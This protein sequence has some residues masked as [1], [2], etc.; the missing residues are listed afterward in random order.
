MIEL[1]DL[2]FSLAMGD[3]SP[4]H[5]VSLG[6][7]S[8]YIR[9]CMFCRHRKVKCDRQHPCSN[10]AKTGSDCLYPPGPGRA[11]KRPRRTMDTQ[12]V[13]RLS[14]L[15]SIIRRLQSHRHTTVSDSD[16]AV[17]SADQPSP[18]TGA[19]GHQEPVD[20]SSPGG[21]IDQHMG[22]LMIDDTKSYYVSNVLWASLGDEI[23]E[24]RDMLHDSPTDEEDE[25]STD[26]A[27]SE[28][29][30]PLMSNAAILGFRALA[31]SLH[32]FHPPLPVSVALS[33]VFNE[34]VIPLVR[35]FHMPT[36]VRIYWDAVASLDSLDKNTEALLFA[37]YYSAVISMQPEQCIKMLGVTR[38]AA[39]EKYRFAVEQAMARADLLNT[40]SIIL[41]QAAV[42]Y[43]SALRNED[44]SRKTW[45]LTSLIYHIAQA[46]GLHRDGAAFGLKPLE[47]ELR[48]RLWYHIC[49]LD[50][51]SEYHGYEP[52]A[53]ESA[54]DTRPPL[55][56]NDS[57]LTAEMTEPPPERE[58]VTEMTFCLMRCQAMRVGWKLNY[59]PPSM[60]GL[61]QQ[62]NGPSLAEKESMIEDLEKRLEQNYL[63]HC[64]SS[65]PF[66]LLVS[67]VGR[68]I[69]AR[70]WLVVH[71]PLW[72]KGDYAANLN[73][74]MRDRLFST[75]TKV[76]ELSSQLLTN[77][78]IT[79]WTWH[80]RTHIQWHAVAFA[81][82]EI[83]SRPPSPECDRAWNY[84][85][86]LYDGWDIQL[87][88]RKSTMWRPIK[89][90]MAKARYVREVQ[91]TGSR[92]HAA[93]HIASKITP[94]SSDQGTP[95]SSPVL[96]ASSRNI[97]ATSM[98]SD[99]TM[100]TLQDMFGME[101]F[102]HLTQ[103]FPDSLPDDIF[104][105]V[106]E[107]S[108]SDGFSQNTLVDD[109]VDGSQNIGEMYFDSI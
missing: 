83:C 49:L 88:D 10:C 66:L 59:V 91:K 62:A 21:S 69:T 45:S 17:H 30:S 80:S 67:T 75:S 95:D 87:D 24:L 73:T 31:H 33:R 38:E 11:P 68:L 15:E 7:T 96:A 23:E 98:E 26:T 50:I 78:N 22:R 77:K 84:V 92:G 103:S 93:Q 63:Q 55:N 101:S 34:N 35:I 86:A 28:T 25:I 76:L 8:P 32:S 46:M 3:T 105:A 43:L 79:R 39:L 20:N 58:G 4:T 53:R 40:Q 99:P 42:L 60:Q 6:N 57:D 18:D 1:L 54:F 94:S 97:C 104:A 82:S 36:T 85:T 100:G 5:E 47:T 109:W 27:P 51:P 44:D 81:L 16:I 65:V 19:Q 29:G 52:I 70:S 90:L 13:D 108:E 37:I 2:L 106:P 71:Y 64:D 107:L 89:R 14:R 61:G 56:I 9:S 48:R 74:T 72:Q 102:D 41:L 12:L